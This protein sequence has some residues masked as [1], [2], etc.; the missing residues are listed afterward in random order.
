MPSLKTAATLSRTGLLS[1]FAGTVLMVSLYCRCLQHFRASHEQ[2]NS[3]DLSYGFWLHHYQ[4]DQEVTNCS[5]RLL[6]HLNSHAR[7]DDPMALALSMNFC[8]VTISLH[9]AAIAKARKGNLPATLITESE[10]RCLAAAMEIVGIVQLSH[11]LDPSKVG[12]P[13]PSRLTGCCCSTCL[14]IAPIGEDF[15]GQQ[16]LLNVASGH[17]RAGAERSC[18]ASERR[19][20]R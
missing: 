1:S 2:D 19:P 15:Q 10:N 16:H 4:L 6:S 13:T 20:E 3:H 14:T 11:Q 5:T 17:G 12:L 9:E 18:Q 7:P 8:A